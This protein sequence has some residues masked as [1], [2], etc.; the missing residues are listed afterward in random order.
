MS[1]INLV[2][3][4]KFLLEISSTRQIIRRYFVVNGFDGALT[5]LG[6]ITGFLFSAS[7]DLPVIISACH[8]AAIALGVSG[9]SSAYISETAERQRALL[10]L[11]DAMIKDLHDSA[12]G[13]AARLM[14]M[15]IAL[16]NGFSPLIISILII[17]PLWLANAGITLPAQ[18]MHLAIVNAL[19]MI[20]LLGVF[21]GRI[22]AISWIR[23]GLQTLVIAV[24]TTALI[25]FVLA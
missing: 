14:P 12:H 6:I 7:A 16:V 18:P 11:E 2:K 1:A 21:L 4:I 19:I 22:A 10:Q 3:Q 25:Y 5:M 15:L 9:V 17:L 8:G 24:L 23:S 13:H 20:F